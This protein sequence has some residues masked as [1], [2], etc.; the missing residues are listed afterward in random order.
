MSVAH[1]NLARRWI[2]RAGGSCDVRMGEDALGQASRVLRAAVGTPRACLLVLRV[3]TDETLEREC[4]RQLADAG[5]AVHTHRIAAADP[6]S[7][8]EAM[9][10]MGTLAE[11]GLTA[12]DLCC[13]VGDAAVASVAAYVCDAWC[14]GMSLVVVP[15]DEVALL[16][17][18][19]LPRP[20]SVGGVRSMVSV[21]PCA[22]HALLDYDIALSDLGS[23]AS[24]Y[25]RAHMVASAM[26]ASE[27]A[28]SELW[29]RAASIM[30]GDAEALRTQL[31]ETAKQ[32]G[33]ASASTAVAV[34]QS[35]DYGHDF[36]RALRAA[37]PSVEPSLALAEGLRFSARV[38]VAMGKLA[39]D[40]MLAQDELLEELGIGEA[41]CAVGAHELVG[42]F[43][44]ERLRRS[45]RI[46]LVAPLAV[47]RVRVTSVPDALLEEHAAAWCDV[48]ATDGR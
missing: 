38:S 37:D 39:L 32:R 16:E 40:D 27:K 23:E 8:E 20:L 30:D 26:A 5:F 4:C 9:R 2:A 44:E 14:S 36:A 41:R 28:F 42:A 3:T 46:L 35:L 43:R 1:G 25:V 12:D 15:T 10:I 48:H 33:Q 47:G 22:K 45:N 6:C 34:R 19:L 13:A 24:A 7:V 11:E 17:G 29:D 31:L 21:R 18:A